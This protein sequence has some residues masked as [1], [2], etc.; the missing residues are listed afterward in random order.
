MNIE[1]ATANGTSKRH[2]LFR[3]YS[4]EIVQLGGLGLRDAGLDPARHILCPVC[5]RPLSE[6][7]V[8]EQQ[9][10]QLEHIPPKCLGGRDGGVVLLCGDCNNNVLSPLDASLLEFLTFW[11]FKT[12]RIPQVVKG[13]VS[14]VQHEFRAALHLSADGI[15]SMTVREGNQHPDFLTELDAYFS[16]ST[17]G[18]QTTIELHHEFRF[19]PDLAKRCLVR[20]AYLTLFRELGYIFIAAPSMERVR[21]L[22]RNE[23]DFD[24]FDATPEELSVQWQPGIRRIV[25]NTKSFGIMVGFSIEVNGA[26]YR[27]AAI[28]PNPSGERPLVCDAAIE[29]HPTAHP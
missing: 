16:T 25:D 2:R 19:R 26:Q 18:S 17:D 20:I 24:A 27:S 11:Q 23:I 13:R 7:L 21:S 12:G 3:K 1:T 9:G 28:L 4:D 14:G 8:D 5:L 10:I 29:L 22:I 6:D 15:I